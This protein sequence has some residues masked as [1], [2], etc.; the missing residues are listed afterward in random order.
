MFARQPDLPFLPTGRTLKRAVPLLAGAAF[1]SLA[2]L[3]ASELLRWGLALAGLT[4]LLHIAAQALAL[5]VDAGRRRR[6]VR[7][8]A[9]M[10]AADPVPQYLTDEAGRLLAL[11]PAA[12]E[13]SPVGL[14]A[15]LAEALSD[16]IANPD[17]LLSALFATLDQRDHAREAVTTEIEAFDLTATRLPLG[18]VLWRAEPGVPAEEEGDL[19]VLRLGPRDEVISASPA[20]RALAGHLPTR[21]EDLVEDL[22]LRDGGTH[23]LKTPAGRRRAQVALTPVPGAGR[24]ALILPL[25]QPATPGAPAGWDAVQ[26]LPVPLLRID[27]DGRILAANAEANGLFRAEDV[28]GLWLSDVL[29]GTPQEMQAWLRETLEGR[30]VDPS[31]FL[32]GRGALRSVTLQVTLHCE[33]D[34]LS[35]H[36]IAVL[37]D[38]TEMKTLEEKFFQSQKMQAIGQLAGGVAH[39]FNNLLTAISGHCD[40]L[41][42]RHEETEDSYDDLIQIRQTANRAASLVGQLLAFSRKQTLRPEVLDLRETL[43]DHAHLL[44]RLVGEKITLTLRH[45]PDLAHIRADRRQLEQVVMNLVVNARDAM[46]DGGRILIETRTLRLHEPLTRDRAEVPAGEY[47]QISVEDEGAGIDPAVIGKIFEPFFTT[48]RQGEG[49]GL[50]LS[51]AYGIVKQTG[52]FIF[53]DHRRP[54]GTRFTLLFPSCDLPVTPPLESPDARRPVVERSG[55]GVVLLVEDEAPVR[56][57]ASRALKHQ[58]FAVLEADCAETAL[59]M[60]ADPDLTVDVFVTDV[61]MPGKDGPTWVREALR[62]R[63][64]TKVVF[65]SGYAEDAFASGADPIPQAIFLP[66]PFSLTALTQTVLRQLDAT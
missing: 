54:C 10:M 1:L 62:D 20:L 51:T 32:H 28:T 27:G 47:V 30:R 4:L 16:R 12:A 14:G 60:L 17:G 65:V 35:R 11:N 37:S 61:I 46:G 3:V 64:R 22:P 6:L 42:M 8:G 55:K 50:G 66:K 9:A 57:F 26:N 21:L 45:D 7:A 36:L 44:N 23:I 49:T 58:G 41:L 15:P 38:M 13:D 52:G 33:D 43:A 40:L 18:L 5:A 39:D 19:P 29:T 24:R 34:G 53:V 63:P 25:E 59:E 48:K 31:H 56:S 2:G